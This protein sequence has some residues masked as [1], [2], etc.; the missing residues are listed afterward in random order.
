MSSPATSPLAL[1][2]NRKRASTKKL[3]GEEYVQVIT[4][5]ISP[6]PVPQPTAA[7][8]IYEVQKIK[9]GLYYADY[10]LRDESRMLSPIGQRGLL[11]YREACAQLLNL[12]TELAEIEEGE[13]LKDELEEN[14]INACRLE[15]AATLRTYEESLQYYACLRATATDSAQELQEK[16]VELLQTLFYCRYGDLFGEACRLLQKQSEVM[17][18]QGW[19]QLSKSYWT[20]TAKM[21][22][23][24]KEA[25]QKML[26]TSAGHEKCRL[27]I[28][29]SQ[30]C[31]AV[32]FNFEDMVKIIEVY[33]KRNEFVH[34][35][36][37]ELIRGADPGAIAKQL[38]DDLCDL[39]KIVPVSE[40]T[41][42]HLMTDLVSSIVD[43]WFIKYPSSP[44][45]YKRWKPTPALDSLMDEFSIEDG[46]S[47]AEKWKL[48][49]ADITKFMR[50]RRQ[51][52]E[53]VEDLTEG[54]AKSRAMMTGGRKEKRVASKD[55]AAEK[56]IA[57]KRRKEWRS[58]ENAFQYP[59]SLANSYVATYG[60]FSEPP[61][62]VADPT[63]E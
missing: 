40:V 1:K 16:T 26:K 15:W 12:E 44:N 10:T 19:Y 57:A 34:A 27:H 4:A 28:T 13:Y 5:L 46:E 24:E 9:S 48:A 41:E 53:R 17:K 14:E 21:L 36:F 25:Y 58:L 3:L 42:L 50:K 37:S 8:E 39:P 59:R 35:N 43:L 29:I 18:V 11:Q 63:L 52:R 22:N 31:T 62:P 47:Q 38:H 49:A 55:L 7:G 23:K 60:E 30:T 61:V 51:E 54:F 32:G 56:E 2:V 45:E 20:D 33:A 6:P